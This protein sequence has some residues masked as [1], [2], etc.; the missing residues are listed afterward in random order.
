MPF[1]AGQAVESR[2][3]QKVTPSFFA[4]AQRLEPHYWQ[5]EITSGFYAWEPCFSGDLHILV[6]RFQYFHF[7][8]RW[9]VVCW[10]K[11][12][13]DY[14]DAMRTYDTYFMSVVREMLWIRKLCMKVFNWDLDGFSAV[15]I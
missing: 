7:P 9:P 12:M 8:I 5:K 3:A 15:A 1:R 4:F 6:A 10:L 2:I 11:R 13:P 14:M